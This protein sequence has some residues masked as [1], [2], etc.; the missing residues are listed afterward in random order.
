MGDAI[1][2]HGTLVSMDGSTIAELAD[3]SGPTPTRAVHEAPRQTS[4]WVQKVSG[5]ING[6]TMTLN[7]NFVPDLHA[8]VITAFNDGLTHDFIITFPDATGWSFEGIV[9]EIPPD[10]PVDGVLTAAFTVEVT[11]AITF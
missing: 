9:T 1:G 3:I 10:A 7:V 6:G 2:S 4:E 8:A 11:D 5:M